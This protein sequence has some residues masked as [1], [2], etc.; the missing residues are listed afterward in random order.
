MPSSPKSPSPP[1]NVFYD[2]SGN[3]YQTHYDSSGNVVINPNN[4]D[5]V[6]ASGNPLAPS[7]SFDASGNLKAPVIVNYSLNEVVDISGA[8]ITNQQGVAADGTEVTQT[9]FNTNSASIDLTLNENLVGVVEEY[10]NDEVDVTSATNVELAKIKDLASKIN[11]TDFQGKGTIEDYSQLF[12]AA[13]KIANDVKQIELDVNVDG[14]NEFASAA[15]DLSKLFN[16]FIVKLQTVSIIDDLVF[17]KS[18]TVA[19]EK[20]WNLSEVFGKFKETILAT[21]TIRVPKSSHDAAVLVQSVMSEVN[22]AMTYINHFVN[23]TQGD[24]SDANLS[25]VEQN[26]IAKA[27]AT[28]DNWSVLCDQGVSIA[29]SNNPD[30]MYI[31]TAS[32]Q[33]KTKASVLAKNT[34][35]LKSK[36]AMYNINQ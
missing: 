22:C 3:P 4:S 28:I 34:S 16:S 17:L 21:A 29:M 26:V 25:A 14:F 7:V 27:V 30:I 9:Q 32:S 2:S 15:D 11:C 24:P 36:L 12:Q 31:S 13:S 20:I 33:L 10:Y 23:P 5:R 35:T 6:D 18:I 1:S 8:R 19:L